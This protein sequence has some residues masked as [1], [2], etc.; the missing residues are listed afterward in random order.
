M[1]FTAQTTGFITQENQMFQTECLLMYNTVQKKS[2]SEIKIFQL[3][4]DPP[5]QT[6]FQSS[7]VFPSINCSTM[8]FVPMKAITMQNFLYF[9][10]KVFTRCCSVHATNRCQLFGDFKIQMTPRINTRSCEVLVRSV[11]SS[12]AKDYHKKFSAFCCSCATMFSPSCSVLR[13]TELAERL[14][15]ANQLEFL[16]HKL[17]T[18]LIKHSLM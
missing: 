12:I 10:K 16:G 4:H 6:F 5:N 18:A 11:D 2:F 1:K 9:K 14:I 13:T 17:F 3:R 8:K 7:H 15:L